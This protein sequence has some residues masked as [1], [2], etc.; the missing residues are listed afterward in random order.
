MAKAGLLGDN[1]S[2]PSV[3]VVGAG[4]TLGGALIHAFRGAGWSVSAGWHRQRPSQASSDEFLV[5]L[6]VSDSISV[7]QGIRDHLD[8]WGRLDALVYASGLSINALLANH[9]EADWNSVMRVNLRGAYFC[10]RAA[11][12]SMRQQR[13]GHIVLIG[14]F[15]GRVGGTGQTGY[16]TSKAALH[17]LAQELALAM[18]GDN[19]Q[20]NVVLPGVLE[21]TM[22]QEISAKIRAAWLQANVLGRLNDAAEV[23]RFIVFLC[24]LEQ[25]SGQLFQ[26]DSRLGPLP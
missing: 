4:G 1:H 11:K 9:T 15:V 7:D 13:G 14:S 6:D 18:G 16:A 10:A 17:G 21:S 8:H 20:V 26:L 12:E 3:L 19:I 23:A 5:Q 2:S 22:T 25:V 24:S